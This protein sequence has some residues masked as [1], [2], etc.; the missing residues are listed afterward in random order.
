M[1]HASARRGSSTV[2]WIIIAVVVVVGL[3]S[4]WTLFGSRLNT[5]IDGV[6]DDVGDPT[7]L[8]ERF[9]E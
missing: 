9:G 8:V 2:Q 1:R 3:V 7:K 5:H 4:S 6:A